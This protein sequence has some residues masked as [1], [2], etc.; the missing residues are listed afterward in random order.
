MDRLSTFSTWTPSR[1]GGSL[2]Y[3]T[4]KQK[5]Y[6]IIIFPLFFLREIK[7]PG[8]V[9]AV[10]PVEGSKDLIALVGRKVCRVNRETG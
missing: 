3:H 5:F 6:A 1:T 8:T 4:E 10:V 2:Q 9:G 7:L